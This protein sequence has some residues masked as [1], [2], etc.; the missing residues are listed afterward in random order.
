MRKLFFAVAASCVASASFCEVRQ[1]D[2]LPDNLDG[3][4]YSEV[5]KNL[6]D[7]FLSRKRAERLS[8]TGGRICRKGTPRGKVVFFDAQTRVAATEPLAK[9]AEVAH[10]KTRLTFETQKTDNVGLANA[11][12]ILRQSQATAAVFLID[13]EKLPVS[14]LVAPNDC[15][16][17]V[18]VAMLVKDK[19]EP[20][21]EQARIRKEV[22]RGFFAAAGGTGSQFMNTI[23][24]DV[25]TVKDLD[26]LVE[27]VPIDLI[28]RTL[29]KL[30]GR[31]MVREEWC[32]YLDACQ[33]GWAP[34]PTNEYQQAIWDKVHEI[35]AKP[36]RIKFDP[37]TDTK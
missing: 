19:P 7:E 14:M 1:M 23:V 2:K 3:L 31:G 29:I 26:T 15:W 21:F 28:S 35:P 12:D 32:T 34:P 30:G 11:S 17:L 5:P 25:G 16:A 24:G 13:D 4:I 36:L 27:G 37:K 9:A 10:R 22:L 6:R 8:Q 33:Q 18:N 20:A